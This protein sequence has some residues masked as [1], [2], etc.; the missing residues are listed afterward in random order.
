MLNSRALDLQLS[1]D[2]MQYLLSQTTQ[3]TDGL[4]AYREIV[5]IMKDMLQEIFRERAEV[6]LVRQEIFS[7]GFCCHGSN[8][9][10]SR[11][12]VSLPGRCSTHRLVVTFTFTKKQAK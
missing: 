7:N 1:D 3:T 4:V 9:C 12:W 6:G 5:P 10:R 2:E 8:I 11:T